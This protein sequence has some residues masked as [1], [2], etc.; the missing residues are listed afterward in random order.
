MARAC[1]NP[2][3]MDLK[4]YC[5]NIREMGKS[6]YHWRVSIYDEKTKQLKAAKFSTIA[7]INEEWDLKLSYDILRRLRTGFRVD[8]SMR[9]K[10]NSFLERWG[11]INVEKISEKKEEV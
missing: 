3:K 4:K 7:A 1:R 11:H 8:T 10:K 6:T 5:V 9:N 2:I